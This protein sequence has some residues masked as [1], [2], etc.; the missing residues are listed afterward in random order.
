M[1]NL[2]R[3]LSQKCACDIQH[4][5]NC[6]IMVIF[7]QKKFGLFGEVHGFILIGEVFG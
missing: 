5:K 2:C 3:Y 4:W 1:N 7:Y 6:H